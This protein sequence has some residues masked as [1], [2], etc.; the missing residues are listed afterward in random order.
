MVTGRRVR[1]GDLVGSATRAS[2]RLSWLDRPSY[3]LEHA[4][5]LAFTLLGGAGD[6]VRN[7]VH[8]TNI[9]HPLHPAVATV[10]V[11]AW[12]AALALDVLDTLSPRPAGFRDATRLTVGV[13]VAGS[14]AAVLTGLADWQ[15]THDE[16]RR[17]GL[18]HGIINT[19]AL[20]L[21]AVSWRDRRRDQHGRARLCSGLGYGLTVASSFLGGNLVYRHQIGVDHSTNELGPADFVPV[22]P[23]SDLEVGQPHHVVADGVGMILVR[24][25]TTIHT[26]GERCPHLGAPMADGWL[27]RGDL[28][29]PWHGS[30]FDPAEGTA[31]RGPASAPLPTY[32]TRVTAGHVEVRRRPGVRSSP[33]EEV[34]AHEG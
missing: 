9:G 7:V 12:T 32:E 3:R 11:G 8:G 31:T 6:R 25:N 17:A 14:A 5:A 34:S 16:T 18:V 30:C 24:D 10:P 27:Y 20:G 21:C 28:V 33:P 23:A 26:L 4:M 29:C 13:G 1:V 2:E 19:A 15:Y 22:L